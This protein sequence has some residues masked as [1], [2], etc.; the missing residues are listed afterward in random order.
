M[1]PILEEV[2]DHETWT[3]A[4]CVSLQVPDAAE[5]LSSM[6][7]AKAIVPVRAGTSELHHKIIGCDSYSKG[8]AAPTGG[9]SSRA[10]SASC[11]GGP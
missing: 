8:G 6:K 9:R 7:Y 4:L 11:A 2:W 5:S 10:L 1:R 3:M